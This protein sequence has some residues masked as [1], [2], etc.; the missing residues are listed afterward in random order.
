MSDPVSKTT[1]P[2]RAL[3]KDYMREVFENDSTV[4]VRCAVISPE[5]KALMNEVEIECK[6]E[7]GEC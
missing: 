1:D 6:K 3:L 4:A 7:R 2:W 5:L